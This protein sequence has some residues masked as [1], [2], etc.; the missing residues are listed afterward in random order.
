MKTEEAKRLVKKA[1]KLANPPRQL[2]PGSVEERLNHVDPPA[3]LQLHSQWAT[4]LS[5]EVNAWVFDL[6]RRNM[7]QL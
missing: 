3:S 7:K 1:N 5:E 6:F 2:L 4:H